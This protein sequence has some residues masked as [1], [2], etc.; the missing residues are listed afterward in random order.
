M[1]G[2]GTKAHCSAWNSHM[3][4]FCKRSPLRLP[5]DKGANSSASIWYHNPLDQIQSESMHW[6][7]LNNDVFRRVLDFVEVE[8]PDG[9]YAGYHLRR[10]K[11][12]TLGRLA[13]TCRAFLEP[14]LNALWKNQL[15]LGPLVQTLPIDAYEE[16]V[17]HTQAITEYHLVLKRPLVP[18]DWSRFDY[19]A[20]RVQSLGYFLVE[21]EDTE[22]VSW[23]TPSERPR[24]REVDVDVVWQL[25]MQRRRRWLLP[26]LIR[27]R[28][29]I[30][31]VPYTSYLSL[32]LGPKLTTF[33]IAFKPEAFR[34]AGL[35]YDPS[36]LQVELEALSSLC[37]SL[38]S[39]E[40]LEGLAVRGGPM[41]RS[42]V[43]FLA[44]RPRLRKVL[45]DIDEETTEDLTFLS[46]SPRHYPFEALQILWVKVPHLTAC[47]TLVKL[48]HT[49]RLSSITCE[50]NHRCNAR[51]VR[52][53][54]TALRDHC[55]KYTL[56]VCRLIQLELEYD[57]D[58]WETFA[59]PQ[60]PS[61][62]VGL[63]ELAPLLEFSNLRDDELVRMADAWPGLIY[64]SFL[65]GWGTQMEAT[66]TWRGIGYFIGR[67]SQMIECRM[68]F[69]TTIDNVALI[70]DDLAFRPN[71]HLRIFDVL[72]SW[73]PDD[74]H[75]FVRAIYA[76]AP[77]VTSVEAMQRNVSPY[78]P[79]PQDVYAF[80]EMVEHELRR[81]RT[82][83]FADS[84]TKDPHYDIDMDDDD[85]LEEWA[86]KLSE[87]G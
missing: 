36:Y 1:R 2:S 15:T 87:T 10:S 12:A 65:H 11:N 61:D 83:H 7:L 3:M 68:A 84:Y 63:N 80:C 14:S 73:L 20:A 9:F 13:R 59:N 17:V 18:S 52:E 4:M 55:A 54:T 58:E 31:D 41:N 39:V 23:S 82:K 51:E 64:F 86:M 35:I 25:C 72:D 8:L 78:D 30:Y 74:L 77:R 32:F 67:C 24:E 43:S 48:M 5:G 27:L 34:A 26:N 76:V 70:V 21:F 66:C 38:T 33:A 16:V 28:W 45:L 19:Y 29:N 50:S 85:P 53:F 75:G 81:L 42:L 44:T 47:T 6:C 37:P 57:E 56:H 79:L 22:A 49:C 46:T 69:D 62:Y 71:N 40:M 60:Y